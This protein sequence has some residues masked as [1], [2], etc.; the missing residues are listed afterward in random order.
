MNLQFRSVGIC[1]MALLL[2]SCSLP[3]GILSQES[4]RTPFQPNADGPA[5]VAQSRAEMTNLSVAYSALGVGGVIGPGSAQF[6]GPVLVSFRDNALANDNLKLMGVDGHDVY[7]YSDLWGRAAYGTD[8][9]VSWGIWTGNTAINGN[10]ADVGGSIGVIDGRG[11][12]SRA[13]G[14]LQYVIG[15]KTPILPTSGMVRY[16]TLP[17]KGNLNA[18]NHPVIPSTHSELSVNFGGANTGVG[19]YIAGACCGI[20]GFSFLTTGGLDH[21]ELS[22][23][24]LRRE[25]ATF[26]GTGISVQVHVYDY[27]S[28][29]TVEGFFAG[30]GAQRAGL[31][32]QANMTRWGFSGIDVLGQVPA[33]VGSGGSGGSGGTGAF[34]ASLDTSSPPLA[35]VSAGPSTF[36]DTTVGITSVTQDSGTGLVTAYTPAE[37]V[38]INTAQGADMGGDALITWGR[39]VNGTSRSSGSGGGAYNLDTIGA[40]QGFHY[41]IGKPSPS[42][43]ASGTANFTLLG[44]TKPTFGDGALPAGTLTS[45]AMAVEWGGAATRV[46][47]DMTLTMP[48]D[49]TYRVLT[50]GGTTTPGTSE[51]STTFGDARFQ[52]SGIPV[53]TTGGARA[54]VGAGGT[55]A[56][57]VEGLFTGPNGAR[58][59]LVYTVNNGVFFGRP[60]SIVGAAAFTKQ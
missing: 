1:L 41:V 37:T 9:L 19:V 14:G 26:G 23:V 57:R 38:T 33:A 11:T 59:G 60:T 39:W 54:C 27:E 10:Q 42:L 3:V 55:C 34:T 40:E 50:T 58:A 18:S 15:A 45:A 16:Q 32:Y 17:T 8:G 52:G 36:T 53:T 25:S 13:W 31:S 7:E 21:P 4:T 43:P 12:I 35:M 24:R 20:A 44:A 46:G 6:M 48:S 28:V 49:G 51:I 2:T 5:A 29:G 47:V 30:S 22:E 56:A